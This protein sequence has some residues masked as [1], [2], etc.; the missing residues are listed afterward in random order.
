[1]S[2]RFENTTLEHIPGVV[3][4]QRE[5][6]PE[7][8]PLE[9]LWQSNH[10]LAH[11]STFHQGQFVIVHE[12]QVVA[13][14]TNMLISTSDWQAHQDWLTT[15]GD[16]SLTNHNPQGNILHGIDISVHPSHRNQGLG[17]LLYLARFDLVRNFK[18]EKYGTVCRIPDFQASGTKQLSDYVQQVVENILVDRTLTPFLKMGLTYAGT[19]EN[20]M[21]DE[22]SGN[23][24]VI[25]EWTP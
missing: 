4:L 8:F 22:E 12:S 13:S 23:A 5:C 14:C 2:Y 18:L 7:P 25:L 19:I 6:F 11:I 21:E 3:A 20:Y 15:I 10:I 16:L 9:S 24:G 17:K 1:M